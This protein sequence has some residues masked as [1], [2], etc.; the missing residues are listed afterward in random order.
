M[1]EA[2]A[3][4]TPVLAW[5]CGSVPE[6]V[7][8]GVSGRIVESVYQAVAAIDELA[9]MDRRLVR[10]CFEHRFSVE[11]MASDYLAVYERLVDRYVS[12]VNTAA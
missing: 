5:H 4:G 2:M 11:R 1:I 3:C 6:I 7:M 9:V 10:D 12:S 8:D